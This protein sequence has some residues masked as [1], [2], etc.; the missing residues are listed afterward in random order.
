MSYWYKSLFYLVLNANLLGCKKK[1][2]VNDV[3]YVLSSK[4]IVANGIVGK[5]WQKCNLAKLKEIFGWTMY[6]LLTLYPNYI[7]VRLAIGPLEFFQVLT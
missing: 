6:L 7:R 5:Q 2:D 4:S 1:K 3:A